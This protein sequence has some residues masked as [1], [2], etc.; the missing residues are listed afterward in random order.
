MLI[1]M[2][3]L[4]EL[5]KELTQEAKECLSCERKPR[6]PYKWGAKKFL[7]ELEVGQM[8]IVKDEDVNWR[9]IQSIGCRMGAEYGCEFHFYIN[10]YGEKTIMRLS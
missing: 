3:I 9:S 8:V 5:A 6:R 2:G 4:K 1:I 10:R 7:S